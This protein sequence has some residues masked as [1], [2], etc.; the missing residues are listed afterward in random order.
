MS[1]STQT[2]LK[3]PLTASDITSDPSHKPLWWRSRGLAF[4]WA[5]ELSQSTT[6]DAVLV[7]WGQAIVSDREQV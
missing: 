1:H 5:K 2:R 4:D 6:A 3:A 7:A